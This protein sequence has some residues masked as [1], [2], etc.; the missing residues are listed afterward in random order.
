MTKIL[1]DEAVVRQVLEALEDFEDAIRYDNEQDD[2]GAHVCCGALSYNPHTKNCRVVKA[3]TTLQ[4]ALAEQPAQQEPVAYIHRQG[5]HWEVSER[6]L[7]ADEKARGW[8]EEPLYTHPAPAPAPAQEPVAFV[9]MR[10]W[11]PI[12]WRDGMIRADVAPFDGQGLFFAPQPPAPAQ[13][14]TDEQ[15][16][17]LMPKADGSAE[18]DKKRVEVL[19]GVW[20]SEYVEVEAWSEQLVLQTA[21]AIEAAHGITKGTS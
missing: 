15:I 14:L 17:A 16:K 7:Y 13:P 8:T 1:I 5:N 4:E 6:F 3:I 21:R 11:P 20:G 12:R 2:I 19:P 18:A 9:D 10:E